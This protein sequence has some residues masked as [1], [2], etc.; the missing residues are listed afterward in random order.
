ML[1]RGPAHGMQGLLG[2][3]SARSLLLFSNPG[4]I[5]WDDCAFR[6]PNLHQTKT[7]LN[8]VRPQEV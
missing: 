2:L 1:V 3:Q 6:Y 7:D 4:Q 8:A 5:G